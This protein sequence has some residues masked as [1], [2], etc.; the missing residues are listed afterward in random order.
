MDHNGRHAPVNVH[1]DRRG[2]YIEHMGKYGFSSLSFHTP[3]QS[4][5][6]FALRNNVTINVYCVDN[7]Y[8][9]TYPIR[10]SSTLLPDRHVDLLLFECDGV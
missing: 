9:V 2:K 8:T 10:A 1:A 7:D 5:G 6:P 3:L 4:V